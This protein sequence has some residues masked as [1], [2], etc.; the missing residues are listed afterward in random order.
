MDLKAFLEEHRRLLKTV[1]FE[2][3]WERRQEFMK[4]YKE[5]E[6]KLEAAKTPE[7]KTK[8]RSDRARLLTKISETLKLRRAKKALKPVNEKAEPVKTEPVKAEPKKYMPSKITSAWT[9]FVH[10]IGGVKE[11]AAAKKAD[12]KAYE[13]FAAKWKKDNS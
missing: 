9:A 13:A 11:A 10:K 6:A 1:P 12:S 4:Q 7:Q 3:R 5:M 2:T 8:E